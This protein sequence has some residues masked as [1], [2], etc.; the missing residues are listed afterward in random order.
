MYI[1]QNT[2]SGLREKMTKKA[3]QHDVPNTMLGL[4]ERILSTIGT[5]T[6]SVLRKKENFYIKN[7]NN[8]RVERKVTFDIKNT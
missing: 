1:E 2:R 8:V 5:K 4:K 3:F 6:M 7:R